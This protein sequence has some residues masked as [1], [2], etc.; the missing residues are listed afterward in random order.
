MERVWYYK[1][2]INI[3]WM[4]LGGSGP[5]CSV[6]KCLTSSFLI[7][8]PSAEFHFSESF[9]G[10]HTCPG[11]PALAFFSHP[12]KEPLGTLPRLA[13]LPVHLPQCLCELL[14]CPSPSQVCTQGCRDP[15]FLSQTSFSEQF[16]PIRQGQA[17]CPLNFAGP[18][19]TVC[20]GY[21]P[22]SLMLSLY[23]GLLIPAILC[24]HN[25]FFLTLDIVQRLQ[26]QAWGRP[27]SFDEFSRV[28]GSALHLFTR[29]APSL[30]RR[31]SAT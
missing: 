2:S 12:P 11:W 30:L 18:S 8:P 25:L 7:T 16:G 26:W 29:P 31:I 14:L 10:P 13:P 24:A 22:D 6:T 1:A 3:C 23:G 9:K 28:P 27:W 15:S 19:R 20:V 17:W 21:S 4:W 5:N